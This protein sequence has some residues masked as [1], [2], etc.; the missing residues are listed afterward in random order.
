MPVKGAHVVAKIQVSIQKQHVIEPN[1]N[2]RRSIIWNQRHTHSN[3]KWRRKFRRRYFPWRC[4]SRHNLYKRKS[5]FG[6]C[7]W[8]HYRFWY[9]LIFTAILVLTFYLPVA[10]DGY[11]PSTSNSSG[12]GGGSGG[13]IIVTSRVISIPNSLIF[14]VF[15]DFTL[16]ALVLLLYRFPEEMEE[17]MV[18]EL[19]QE[20]DYG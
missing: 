16:L 13:A 6:F 20:E 5:T 12:S 10:I 19:D 11:S 15:P 7:H 8:P 2:F 17:D 9:N 14:K 1:R 3:G 18:E 4:W